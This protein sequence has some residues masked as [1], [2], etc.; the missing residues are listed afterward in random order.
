MYSE[1]WREYQNMTAR[2]QSTA[3]QAKK[4]TTSATPTS[5]SPSEER[6]APPGRPPTVAQN[7]T[8]KAAEELLNLSAIDAGAEAGKKAGPPGRPPPPKAKPGRPPPPGAK[9]TES[10]AQESQQATVTAVPD[11]S[12]ELADFFGGAMPAAK[13]AATTPSKQKVESVKAS[14]RS[15]GTSLAAL[16]E[17]GLDR[18]QTDCPAESWWI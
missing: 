12:D 14:S 3:E 10:V 4:L 16:G 8:Q 1:Q 7:A 5:P 6:R 2:A 9:K 13:P 17:S 18:H 15:T 11:V